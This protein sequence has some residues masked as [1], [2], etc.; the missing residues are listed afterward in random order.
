MFSYLHQPK[1]FYKRLF[2]LALPVI[3]QNFITT[4]LGFLDTFMVGL[5][6]SDQM[7]AVTVANVPVFIIQLIVFGL[8]SGSSVL[9]SQYWGRS[10]RESIN[11]V[12]GIGF[13][14]AGGVSVLFAIVLCA[15]PAQVLYLI[16]DNLTLVTL[17]EP[18]LRIVGFSYIFNS[19]SSIY[20]GMQR[21]IENPRFGMIVFATSMLCNTIDNYVLI[22]GKLG[23]PAFGITGAAV[24]T[25]LSRVAAFVIVSFY[26]F[27][28]RTM[29][30][31]PHAIF[32]PGMDMLHRFLRYSAPVLIN[33]TLW[34]TGFSLITV[35]MGHM[36]ESS[37]L[38][39]AYTLAGNIDRLVTSGLF[40]VAAATAVIIGK[41]IGLGNLKGVYNIGKALCFTA[42]AFGVLL[43]LLEYAMFATLM[44]PFVMPLFSLSAVA[45]H[46]CSVMLLCYACSIPLHSFSTTMAVGVLRG[47]GDVNASLVIDNVPLWF[48]TLPLMCLLG[49]VLK[50]PNEVFCLC[51]MIEYILKTPLVLIRL[52]SGKWIHDITRIE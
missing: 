12:M 40:G 4:S 41:E 11:R 20:I 34:G 23:L 9:I 32:H 51:L 27:R 25:L 52:R 29:P 6:G 36:A 7:S 8:Q 42:L 46:L 30:L 31:M 48:G 37:D 22:F 45:E 38:I 17:A 43:G 24:A 5:L 21:S 16:T 39:A 50:V 33:E 26:S 19:I 15:F 2:L 49:L 3:V 14:I 10:D 35:I 47:G 1:G 18:Y 28:C 44:R 13:F